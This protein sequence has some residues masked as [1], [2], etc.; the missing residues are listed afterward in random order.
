MGMWDLRFGSK[1]NQR[2]KE[3]KEELGWRNLITQMEYVKIEEE[4]NVDAFICPLSF[5]YSY[6]KRK[7][8][9][10]KLHFEKCMQ[11]RVVLKTAYR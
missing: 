1:Q 4:G 11:E 9:G 3:D 5:S 8:K 2:E 6:L 10:H 7:K